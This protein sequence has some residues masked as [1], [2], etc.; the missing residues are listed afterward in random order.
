MFMLSRTRYR[1]R[2]VRSEDDDPDEEYEP[3]YTVTAFR[4][5]GQTYRDEYPKTPPTKSPASKKQKVMA[6]GP[7][8]PTQFHGV[9]LEERAIDSKGNRLPWAL[10]YH[11]YVFFKNEALITVL[12]ILQR[13]PQCTW[14]EAI[15]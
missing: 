8:Q 2:H 1:K 7:G 5:P 11:E 4:V 6:T 10:E 14:A 15:S 12:T 9:P 13:S 3:E